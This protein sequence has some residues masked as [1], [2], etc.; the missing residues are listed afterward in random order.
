[1]DLSN[2]DTLSTAEAGTD[3]ELEHPVTGEPIKDDDGKPWVISIRGSDSKTVRAIA[4]K[5]QNRFTERLRKRGQFGDA[6]TAESEAVEKLVAATIGWRGLV[7]DGKPYEFSPENAHKLY[8]DPR[9]PWI[10]EQVQAAMVDRKR[11]FSKG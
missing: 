5:Q 3:V 4:K 6:D 1:M 7:M 8:S 11:F 10:V 2:L 9:F